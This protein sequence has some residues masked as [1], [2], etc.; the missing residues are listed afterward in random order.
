[1]SRHFTLRRTLPVAILCAGL[2]ASAPGY[3]QTRDAIRDDVESARSTGA[4][5]LALEI[6][7]RQPDAF[8][9]L[10]LAQLRHAALAQQLRFAQDEMRESTARTRTQRLNTAL[11]DGWR[12]LDELPDSGEFAPLRR[13]VTHD[14]IF[15]LALGGRAQSAI[16]LFE[17]MNKPLDGYPPYVLIAA[18]DAYEFQE[19]LD[20]AIAAYETALRTAGPG[21]VDEVAVRE[22]L[23]YAYLDRGRPEDALVNLERVTKASPPLVENAPV[24]ETPNADYE[25]AARMKAQYLLYTGNTAQG[26]VAI[27]TLQ[28]DAPFSTG[29]RNAAADARM[30]DG[31]PRAARDAFELA[32]QEQP[33]DTEALLGLARASLTL[34]DVRTAREISA[35]LSERLPESGAVRNLRRD[36]EVYDSPVLIVEAAAS[37]GPSDGSVA[38]GK[39]ASIDTKVYTAPLADNYRVFFHQFAGKAGIEDQRRSRVRN[40]AGVEYRRDSVEASAEIH[41]SIGMG[42]N[43]TGVTGEVRLYPADAW[44]ITLLADSDSN[45]LPWRAYWN[46]VHGWTAATGVRYQPSARRYFDATYRRDDYSDGNLRQSLALTGF[47]SLYDSPR[48]GVSGFLTLSGSR[49]R[50]TET[51]YFS[52]SHDTTA[53]TTIMYE[54]RPWRDGQ[55]VFRQRVYGTVGAYKQAGFST[56][57][58]WEV[59][60]EQSWDLARRTNITYGVGY[61]RRSYD[62]SPENRASA[63][64]S[65]NLPF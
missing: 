41:R 40:G 42:S 46:G 48:H 55:R 29:L 4:S 65:L 11:S 52:P 17:G 28:H 30:G 22:R 20:P 8:S 13:A 26:L 47:Q 7:R 23:F 21:D 19:R 35:G 62:G 49:N 15:G 10:E 18:G 33:G 32:V 24:A 59:R 14:M 34:R 58:L 54:W 5:G 2:G 60:L 51:D 63:Y 12:L 56:E 61:G 3:A 27:D 50:L 44:R 6:A 64:F 45:E 53:Q 31:R 25:R 1:M 38:A 57:P 9:P 36:V 39:E 16:T 37:R 43:R